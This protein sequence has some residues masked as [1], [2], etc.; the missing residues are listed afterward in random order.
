MPGKSVDSMIPAHYRQDCFFREGIPVFYTPYGPSVSN[1]SLEF[2]R[3]SF[4]K[5]WRFYAQAEVEMNA[6]LKA[7]NTR[8]SGFAK[9]DRMADIPKRMTNRKRIILAPHHTIFK[10]H[11]SITYGHFLQ[12]SDLLSRLPQ[13][14][15]Q[16]DFVF[17]PHPLLLQNLN[18]F[19][20]EEKTAGWLAAMRRNS[21]V[22]IQLGGNYLSTFVH[23]DALIH[24]CDSFLAEYL[25][26][27]QPCCYMWDYDNDLF[28]QFSILG[29][30]CLEAHYIAREEAHIL[31]FINDI[32]LQGKD[33]MR[34]KRGKRLNKLKHRYPYCSQFIVNDIRN[35]I[36]KLCQY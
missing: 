4:K 16:I 21:N 30:E 3:G 2:I 19:W 32:V 5:F 11:N 15:S 22:E 24:D 8:F 13:I 9:L 7:D 23:S 28:N 1:A 31:A 17:R 33:T 14:F 20:G 35:E 25:F 18:T 26:T 10:N 6:V 36:L 12:Y 34:D 27:G 29:R